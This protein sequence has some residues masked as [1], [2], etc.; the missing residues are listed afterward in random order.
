MHIFNS[1]EMLKFS[2]KMFTVAVFIWLG[3]VFGVLILMA[4]IRG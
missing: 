3:V 4:L 1:A 2:T